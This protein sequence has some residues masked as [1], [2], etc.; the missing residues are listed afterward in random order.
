MTSRYHFDI[1]VREV[2]IMAEVLVRDLDSATVRK[3]KQQ[4]RENGRSLQSE[5][6][7]IIESSVP[8]SMAEF[9]ATA[10]RIRRSLGKRGH[11]D[12][13]DLLRE[14]RNR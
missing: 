11:S 8:L 6:K 12:S 3:L 10:E 4:A 13:V 5:L 14:D 7:T 2:F 9:R 1:I